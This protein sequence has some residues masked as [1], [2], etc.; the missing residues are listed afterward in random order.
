MLNELQERMMKISCQI[1]TINK[2]K[3]IILKGPNETS[4]AKTE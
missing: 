2:G 3:E 4:E 1:E